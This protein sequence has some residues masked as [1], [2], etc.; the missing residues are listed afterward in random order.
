MIVT[1]SAEVEAFWQACREANGIEASDCHAATFAD[2][3][4]TDKLD[5]ITE[6]CRAGHK[7]G[8]AHL[9]IEFELSGVPRRE[10]GD[11]LLV[12]D[13]QAQPVCVVRIVKVEVKPFEEAGPDFAAR[14]NEGDASLEYWADG[15][16]GYFE[17]QCAAWGRE[18]SPRLEVV[19]EHFELVH[20]G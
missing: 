14:E 11:H 15:H 12:L 8:T 19:C 3:A 20:T 10:V 16:R 7:R 9:A 5:Y 18:W 17:K 1:K 13:G 6:H 2:P 4:H